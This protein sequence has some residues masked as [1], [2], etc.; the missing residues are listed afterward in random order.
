MQENYSL[1]PDCEARGTSDSQVSN[2][3]TSISSSH[4]Y[5]LRFIPYAL[6]EFCH[7][8]SGISEEERKA[9]HNEVT[10]KGFTTSLE[11]ILAS[12]ICYG[13]ER[14]IHN[15]YCDFL[16]KCGCTWSWAGGWSDCNFLKEG[17]PK[18]PWCMSRTYVAWTT[19]ILPFITMLLTYIFTLYHRKA[20]NGQLDY[21]IVR[22]FAAVLAYFIIG[23]FVG[24]SFK[25]ADPSY[26][27]FVTY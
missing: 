2:D 3:I 6:A 24:L 13:F 1:L 8:C 10:R 17:V 7:K 19:D 27:H 25:L 23:F 20:C 21:A 14:V 11:F 5:G 26:N 15:K 4:H 12:G 22:L 16:F 18:C 9:D